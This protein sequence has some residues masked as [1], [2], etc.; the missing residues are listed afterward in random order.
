MPITNYAHNNQSINQWGG[1]FKEF[2]AIARY[3]KGRLLL[4]QKLLR[5]H[6]DL[7]LTP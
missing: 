1:N 2:I 5:G 7:I 6:E 4:M 3:H